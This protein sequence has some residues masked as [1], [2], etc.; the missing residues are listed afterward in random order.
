MHPLPMATT[1]TRPT[2]HTM[3]TIAADQSLGRPDDGNRPRTP[4]TRAATRTYLASGID[5]GP[6]QPIRIFL[7]PR[8]AAG[9]RIELERT[10]HNTTRSRQ[11]RHSRQQVSFPGGSAPKGSLGENFSAVRRG[12]PWT[13]CFSGGR[14]LLLLLL[15]Q[16]PQRRPSHENGA[17]VEFSWTRPGTVREHAAVCQRATLI[18]R[19]PSTPE[20]RKPT[21]R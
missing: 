2:E 5:P 19:A 15:L 1:P 11:R 13:G 7:L 6:I 3:R 17:N 9:N 16:L 4:P 8:V 12:L 20:V 14:L 21:H 18:S 10:L